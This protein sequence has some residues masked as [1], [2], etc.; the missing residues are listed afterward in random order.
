MM[1]LGWIIAAT[2]VISGGSLIGVT[3]LTLK[4]E[5][6][7]RWLMLLVS[8]S[9]GALMG[10]A[11]LHL[12]PEANE[13]FDEGELFGWVLASF[14]GFFLVE[15]VFH[16]RHCHDGGRCEDHEFF[17][18][19]N[20]LGDGIHNFIDGLVLAG[21]FMTEIRLGII[22]TLAVAIHEIPQ[23]IGDFGVLLYAGWPKKKAILANLA[24]ALTAVAG[25]IAGYLLSSA[26]AEM[27]KYLL[28]AAA[29]GFIYIGAADLL[30]EIR[31]ERNTDKSIVAMGMFVA[32]IIMMWLLGKIV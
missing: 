1:T 9:A 30:P 16:W 24:V 18:H 19:M 17:G 4:E 23:E 29:G 5:R 22:A 3:A 14:V 31:R 7:Q 21:A 10:G 12:L 28:A 25:G 6:L 20:L 8:L 27:E 15:K 2:L 13:M 11:F 32:G 26:T